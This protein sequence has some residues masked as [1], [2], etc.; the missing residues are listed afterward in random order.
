MAK[1]VSEQI[2]EILKEYEDDVDGAI[3]K[4][5]KTIGKESKAKLKEVSPKDHGDYASGWTYKRTDDKEI[6]VYNSKYPGLTHLL[7]NGHVIRNQHGQY[8]RLN[9]DN[10]IGQ[11]ES[12]YNQKFEQ[13]VVKELNKG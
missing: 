6:T 4:S 12:E 10:H 9:G 2:Q 8:G 3:E 5:L 13:E 1:S 7:S 11:V